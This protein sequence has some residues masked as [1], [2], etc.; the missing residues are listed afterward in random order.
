MK[1][2]ITIGTLTLLSLMGMFGC[3]QQETVEALMTLDVKADY[4]EKEW[5]VQDFLDVEYIPLETND[6]F[7]TQ[8]SVKAIGKRFV[9]V[10][11]LLNDGNIFVFDRKTGKAVRKI[12]RKGQGAEE[13]AFS[14][15]SSLQVID[16]Y[17]L[18]RST[19]DK[20]LVFF[21]IQDDPVDK[22]ILLGSLSLPIDFP[23]RL[24]CFS[25]KNE[26]IRL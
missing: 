10:T 2:R 14:T 3:K 6:E 16:E 22:S 21:L 19:I 20:H 18:V 24:A 26:D 5:V 25:V 9:L 8:G 15:G 1:K 17:L 13:Y 4:P 12:N 23:D 7:I 11:N